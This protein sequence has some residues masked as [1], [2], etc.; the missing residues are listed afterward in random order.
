VPD[1]TPKAVHSKPS[2]FAPLLTLLDHAADPANLLLAPVQC[3]CVAVIAAEANVRLA[4]LLTAAALLLPAT[5]TR[6]A[7]TIATLLLCAFAAV[8][9]THV[10]QLTTPPVSSTAAVVSTLRGAV[11]DAVRNTTTLQ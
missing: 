2:R 8:A 6:H 11:L 1:Q 3:S 4:A 5:R 10:P 9:L 7:V